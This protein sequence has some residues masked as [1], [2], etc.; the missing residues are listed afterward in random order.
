M[1]KNNQHFT[2]TP[3]G[4][5]RLAKQDA[6]RLKKTVVE[7]QRTT[8]ALTRRDLGDWRKAWQLAINVDS[9]NRQH[10]Y[11]IYRDV[12]VDLHLSGCI[13]QRE[14]FVM[15]RSFKLVNEK[16]QE[17]E[18][19]AKYFNTPWFKQLMKHALDANY[20]G[21]SLIELGNPI[22]DINGRMTYDGVVLIPRK[23]VIP[24]YHRVII[25]LGQD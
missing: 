12:D 25:D 20:W 23:H 2:K 7:L 22:T 8:D 16:D 15:A 24:E 14:G 18:E 21:H 6:K 17:D 4:T 9:P 10:L 19:A 13:Q 1:K 11:D 3:F 5:L